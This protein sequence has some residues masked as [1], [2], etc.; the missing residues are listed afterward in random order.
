MRSRWRIAGSLTVGA[1]ALAALDGSLEAAPRTVAGLSP[2]QAATIKASL[3]S[4]ITEEK[5]A[6]AALKGGDIAEAEAALADAKGPLQQAFSLSKGSN[7]P[8]LSIII[9]T[10][11]SN[12][13]NAVSA[14]RDA[15]R[16]AP[17]RVEF[18]LTK[19]QHASAG[20]RGGLARLAQDARTP[21]G[22]ETGEYH[23]TLTING[24]G[25]SDGFNSSPDAA[26]YTYTG[27]A[28]SSFE[29]RYDIVISI[30]TSSQ[31]A[32]LLGAPS[33]P[34]F[35]K[36]TASYEV[37]R[38][39][40]T[41]VCQK[42][43]PEPYSCSY[44]N[45]SL[46][47]DYAR[48]STLWVDNPNYAPGSPH[49]DYVAKSL[50][51]VAFVLVGAKPGAKLFPCKNPQGTGDLHEIGPGISSVPGLGGSIKASLTSEC[52]PVFKLPLKDLGEPS[53]SFTFKAFRQDCGHNYDNGFTATTT[54]TVT[55]SKH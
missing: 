13:A 36:G 50:P 42:Y 9:G 35:A 7:D 18:A 20:K 48:G 3:N 10:A 26:G 34:F 14:L 52:A 27:T 51:L 29:L 47:T 16:P 41:G 6:E 2:A 44:S 54:Y 46:F 32:T 8:T 23:Y 38:T 49:Q 5:K 4:A 40:G 17:D 45:L 24:D 43:A 55:L 53:I 37:T 25:Q 11:V 12:D 30:N 28:T 39:C 15:K 31:Y 33:A 22:L 19:L 1:L 21:S